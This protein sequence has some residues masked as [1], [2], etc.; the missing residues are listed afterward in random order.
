MFVFFFFKISN[1]A[2]SSIEG[3]SSNWTKYL[4]LNTFNSLRVIIVL[5]KIRNNAVQC[6]IYSVKKAIHLFWKLHCILCAYSS[7]LYAE[8]RLKNSIT[9][10]EIYS[11]INDLH[12]TRRYKYT[13]SR[14]KS[15]TTNLR[16]S[17]VYTYRYNYVRRYIHILHTYIYL[18]IHTTYRNKHTKFERKQAVCRR[19]K[20]GGKK[21]AKSTRCI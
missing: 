4:Q 6:T 5:Y 19:R 14:K 20:A 21:P 7:S 16:W 17:F 3:R 8:N 15:L 18:Y 12:T 11:W 13:R 10:C 9:Q 1:D 2:L